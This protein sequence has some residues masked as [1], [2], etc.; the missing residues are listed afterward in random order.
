MLTALL[1]LSVFPAAFAENNSLSLYVAPYGSDENEGTL[2]NPLATIKGARDKIREIKKVSGLHDG[3]VTVY[4]RD[5]EYSV[6]DYEMKDKPDKVEYTYGTFFTEEDSGT[7]NAPIEYC[8]Y[9]NENPVFT[10]GFRVSKD[11]FSTET[12]S[13]GTTVKT[14]NVK[15]FLTEKLGRTPNLEEYYPLTKDCY[16]TG[17]AAYRGR[18]MYSLDKGENLHIARYPNKKEGLYRENPITEYMTFGKVTQSSS[19]SATFEY[20]DDRISQY[21]TTDDVWVCGLFKQVFWQAEIPVAKIDAENKTI[22]TAVAP[23]TG[24]IDQK[25]FF[26]FNVLNEL[27]KK[28]EYYVSKE[29]KFYVYDTGF[30]YLNIPVSDVSFMLACK[31]A[32]YITFQN[33]AF[34]NSRHSAIYVRGGQN[35]V[36][37]GCDFYNFCGNGVVIGE[38]SGGNVV[39]TFRGIDDSFFS[40][41]KDK[42]DD[43]KIAYQLANE[44]QDSKGI[45]V[46]GK[47]HGIKNSVVKN[48]GFSSVV[49]SGGNFYRNE[50]CGYFIENCDLSFAGVNKRTY[51]ASVYCNGVYGAKITKNNLSHNSS[52]AVGGY[53]TKGEITCNNIF[54]NLSDSYDMGV[55]YINYITP[56]IDLIID[57]NYFHDTLPEHEITGEESPQSQRSAIA[58]DNN[59]GTGTKITN[60]IIENIPKGIFAMGGET[61]ENN[62]FID[63]FFPI[64]YGYDESNYWN[65]P[66]STSEESTT[67]NGS[68]DSNSTDNGST[69][70]VSDESTTNNS[71]TAG[72]SEESTTANGLTFDRDNFFSDENAQYL[73]KAGIPAMRTWPYFLSGEKG[74]EIRQQWKTNYP[75][76][77]NWIEIVTNQKHNGK[78]FYKYD[79]NLFVNTCG[80]WYIR[81]RFIGS[82]HIAKSEELDGLY[83]SRNDSNVYSISPKC[84]VDY[85]N[86]NFDLTYSAKVRYGINTV[87]LTNVGCHLTE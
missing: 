75:D 22:T 18:I 1:L 61:V 24:I 9:E 68:T 19:D 45:D 39:A 77:T 52:S 26:V 23:P 32:S 78:L 51:E 85:Q 17:Q 50:E 14:F 34:E 13:N 54:D 4:L 74:N 29:G 67:A 27:D 44:T 69:A 11:K 15:E 56:V 2:D 38:T 25:S 5:G 71:S 8:A 72:T 57:H 46:R 76:F 42:S 58:F 16:G 48:T 59:Y 70:G 63:C 60:N 31:D 62:I 28:G 3:G 7:Q 47:N 12:L 53:I 40:K 79:H 6:F 43:E 73:Y 20:T 49:L 81:T 86:D 64:D 84:F 30:E 55:I 83:D 87:D 82:Q 65:I 35:V 21:T 36:V 37:D 33:I 10:G 66:D 80:Y 41:I